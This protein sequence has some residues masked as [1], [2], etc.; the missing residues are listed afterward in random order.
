[1][2]QA[3]AARAARIEGVRVSG[4][5]E[6]NSVFVHLPA[7]A[8]VALQEWSFF[9]EWDLTQSLVRWM[10][11][12]ATTSDDVERFADGVEHLLRAHSQG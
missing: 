4:T 1:M 11:S 10:T 8:I 5:P 2:A 9:W 12:F 7:S 6:V 3:L